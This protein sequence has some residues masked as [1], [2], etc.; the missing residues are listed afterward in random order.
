MPGLTPGMLPGSIQ[1]YVG[2]T[3]GIGVD[4]GTLHHLKHLQIRKPLGKSSLVDP[5]LSEEEV[6]MKFVQDLLNWVEEMQVRTLAM[7]PLALYED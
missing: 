5:N 4:H 3:G 1:S 7:A 2:S 6:N